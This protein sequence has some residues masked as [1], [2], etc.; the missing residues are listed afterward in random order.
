MKLFYHP[1]S[2]TSR[3]I[4]LFAAENN[5]A[6]DMQV[7]DLFT[8]EQY[9]PPFEAVN[10]N[11]L[12]PVLEDGALRLTESSAILKYLAEKTGSPLYPKDLQQRARVNERMDWVN[13]Q[14]C[15]DFVYGLVYPQIFSFHKRRSDEAQDATLQWGKE[16]AQGWM[17]VLNDHVL[18]TGNAYLCGD[19]ITIAD[20]FASS[21]VAL[22]E[23]TGSDFS[24]YPNVKRWLGRMKALK[25]WKQV[26]QAIDGF[27][28]TLKGTPMVTV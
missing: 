27:G 7:V 14:L 20:Y 11:H 8:G 9:Q 4:M 23:L 2:T 17:K 10:P 25:S 16:R 18:G 12:V 28:A 13:T 6:L 1:A 5:L 21:F 19:A 24:A 15:R 26:N 3:P 22:G